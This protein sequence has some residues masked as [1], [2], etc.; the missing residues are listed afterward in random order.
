MS[1]ESLDLIAAVAEPDAHGQAAF[2]LA[3]S[4][5]HS[6]IEVGALTVEQAISVVSTALELKREFA[7]AQ[8]ES[9]VTMEKSLTLLKGISGSLT[10]DIPFQ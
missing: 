7:E 8:G 6:L 1:T 10:S 3:E 2:M 5:L 4:I 9:R